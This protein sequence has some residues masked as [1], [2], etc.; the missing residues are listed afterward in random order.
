MK[1]DEIM[2]KLNNFIKKE[3][4]IP[5]NVKLVAL[6]KETKKDKIFPGKFKELIKDQR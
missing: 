5:N 3:E 1:D 2:E 4:N 6:S